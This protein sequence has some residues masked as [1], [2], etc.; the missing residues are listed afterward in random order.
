MEWAY[1]RT[2]AIEEMKDAN[3]L[4]TDEE[5]KDCQSGRLVQ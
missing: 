3:G 1:I 2:E 5:F 4:K